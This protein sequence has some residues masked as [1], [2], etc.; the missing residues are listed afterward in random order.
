MS[1]PTKIP[2]AIAIPPTREIGRLCTFLPPGASTIPSR[3]E[4]GRRTGTKAMVS[5]TDSSNVEKKTRVTL[6]RGGIDSR[7]G[8]DPG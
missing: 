5:R 3:R 6:F 1:R 2:T 7:P 4:S 8:P